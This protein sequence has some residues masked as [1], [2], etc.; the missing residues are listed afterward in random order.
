MPF[1]GVRKCRVN[2]MD[3]WRMKPSAIHKPISTRGKRC[4][5]V[6]AYAAMLKQGTLDLLRCTTSKPLCLRVYDEN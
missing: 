2:S 1:A 3:Y 5:S 4:L 6:V